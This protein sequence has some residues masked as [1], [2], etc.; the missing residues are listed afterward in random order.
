MDQTR[1]TEEMV[2]E[3]GYLMHELCGGD[4]PR[5]VYSSLY[6]LCR[7]RI[8]RRLSTFVDQINHIVH[9]THW[10]EQ[11]TKKECSQGEKANITRIPP[12]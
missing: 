10:V 8:T 9:A 11:S 4:H 12:I 5:Q 1:T 7:L 2:E 6:G 3:K